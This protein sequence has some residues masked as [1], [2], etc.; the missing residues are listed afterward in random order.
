MRHNHK[1]THAE[2]AHLARLMQRGCEGAFTRFYEKHHR[3]VFLKCQ[4]SLYSYEDAEDLTQQIF[5]EM[6]EKIEKWDGGRYFKAYFNLIVK[7][8]ISHFLRDQTAQKRRAEMVYLDDP[9]ATLQI[10]T[11]ETDEGFH[12][13]QWEGHIAVE[14]EKVL[15]S[16][17]KPVWRL[18]WILRHREGYDFTEIARITNRA[19]ATC[20]T[21]AWRVN[22]HLREHLKT[23]YE[24][25][26]TT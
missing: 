23:F 3:A 13:Q 2:D 15:L 6:W 9:T 10:A 12:W 25:V 16:L 19:Q 5:S 17:N 11:I 14:I 7:R 24:R 21:Y 8:K 20:W 4:E 26:V 22:C 1:P 18:V